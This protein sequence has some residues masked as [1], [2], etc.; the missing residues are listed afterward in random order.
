MALQICYKQ[1][2]SEHPYCFVPILLQYVERVPRNGNAG[3]KDIHN[4]KM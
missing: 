4:V 3:Y 1:Y 2:C